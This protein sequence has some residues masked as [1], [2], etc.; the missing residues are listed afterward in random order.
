MPTDKLTDSRCRTIKPAEK[1]QK[2]FD[3][4]GLHLYVSPKGAKVWRLAYRVAGKPQTMSLGPYPRVT[5]AQARAKRDEVRNALDTG[6]DPMAP[7]RAAKRV[8]PTL[9]EACRD[10]WAGR[11][12]LSPSYR[13]NGQRALEMHV[14]PTLGDRQVASITRDDVLGVLRPMDAAGLHV[15]VRKTRMWLSQ[16]FDRAVEHGDAAMNPAALID[17]RKAFG[18]RQVEHFAALSLADVPE[19]LRRLSLERE[20]QSVLACRMLALTW[21]RT[22]ELRMMLW[23]E[24]DGDTWT[25]PAGRMK[26]R[27]DHVVPLSRQASQLLQQL[28]DRAR[29]SVYVFP[30]D[31]RTDRPMSENAVLYLLGRIGY[32][33]R[34]T[35]H[36]WRTV[37]STWA[38]EH[39][40]RA[41]IIERQL[42]HVPR[43]Q[44]RAVYNRAEW[45]GERRVMLQAW[46]DWLDT[47]QRFRLNAQRQREG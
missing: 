29:G 20:L 2:V 35:G 39:G 22:T 34:M 45:L 12:D 13:A 40:Y 37:A 17:P 47:C 18:R 14:L 30:A 3:G 46:A 21:V 36:G 7:R 31:H 15:Y 38:N 5:L 23:S 19:L 10:Y 41:D 16:V 43:D 11:G 44:V 27:R 24:V 9:R 4:G 25:I 8:G 33:G 1:A 28:R 26:R 6:Q 32:Q 42:A